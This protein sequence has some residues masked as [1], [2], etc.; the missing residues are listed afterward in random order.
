MSF[1]G[2]NLAVS[3]GCDVDICHSAKNIVITQHVD[4]NALGIRMH[5][6]CS[7]MHGLCH[8]AD[9]NVFNDFSMFLRP[10][11]VLKTIFGRNNNG[12]ILS[13]VRWITRVSS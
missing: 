7:R 9:R 11:G 3:L 4:W 2:N 6:L 1:F 5:D 13:S 10:F 12:N 8:I